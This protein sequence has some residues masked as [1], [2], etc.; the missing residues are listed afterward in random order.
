[1]QKVQFCTEK[2]MKIFK[3]ILIILVLI[4]LAL[5]ISES[6]TSAICAWVSVLI[7]LSL[8]IIKDIYKPQN[9]S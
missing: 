7:F 6:N 5:A 2:K 8:E 9:K 3:I 1:M 4:D